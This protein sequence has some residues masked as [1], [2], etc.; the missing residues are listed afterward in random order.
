MPDGTRTPRQGRRNTRPAEVKVLKTWPRDGYVAAV[1]ESKQLTT[2]E[3]IVAMAY[4]DHA[5][6]GDVA[7]VHWPRLSE[8]T[9]IR[10]KSTLWKVTKALVAAGWLVQVEKARQH[11][12]PRY[13]LVVP[14]ADVRHTYDVDEDVPEVVEMA[15][16][17]ISQRFAR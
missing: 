15:E 10:A 11:R 12:S 4:A 2:Q 9:G 3:R 17:R 7:W 8:R 6:D 5:K 13:R 14:E 1:W 16:Y